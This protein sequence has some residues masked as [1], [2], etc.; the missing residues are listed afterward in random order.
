V[1]CVCVCAC[2]TW[3][4]N[5]FTHEPFNLTAP[6]TYRS[7][8]TPTEAALY[9]GLPNILFV[10]EQHASYTECSR[11]TATTGLYPCYPDSKDQLQKYLLPFRSSFFKATGFSVSGGGEEYPDGYADMILDALPTMPS[12]AGVLFDDF[13]Y[14]E[15]H[16]KLLQNMSARATAVRK[17]VF[18]CVYTKELAS[19][20]PAGLK[21]YL[22]LARRPMLWMADD[23]EIAHLDEHWTSLEAALD[24]A[25]GRENF[26][27]ML[28]LY[29]FNY[30][31][32]ATE[33]PQD[34]MTT[35][36]DVALKVRSAANC[37][38]A[39]PLL[40]FRQGPALCS[41]VFF[42]NALSRNSC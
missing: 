3:Q 38:R 40:Q 37:G 26:K 19:L 28:G 20:G 7:R 4:D 39:H 29:M 41:E 17:D 13:V 11:G 22:E 35:Q 9:M 36:L 32:G 8:I 31:S 12:S 10:Y 30:L 23:T 14:D 24:A 21:P 6:G 33:M 16:L 27:P 15:T 34:L 18:L 42:F 25:G 1:W 2:A 5:Y